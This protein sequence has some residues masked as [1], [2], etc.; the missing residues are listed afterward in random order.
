MDGQTTDA[1]EH[2]RVSC[3]CASLRMATRAVARLYDDALR[4]H[5]LRTTQLSILARLADEGPSGLT[6]L[7]ARLAMD[8]TT[9][10]RELAPL[11]G[12]GLVRIEAGDDRRQRIVSLTD[13]GRALREAALPAW[14]D[15]QRTVRERF[16]DDRTG[17]LVAELHDLVAAARAG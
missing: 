1:I 11:A 5:G 6:R 13:D 9:L 14:R 4:P 17:V 7:A 12:R 2:A 15:A 8:R 10:A 3:V 16:G